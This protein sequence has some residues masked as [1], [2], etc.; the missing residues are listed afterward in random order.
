MGW[1]HVCLRCKTHPNEKD[2]KK[3]IRVD[4]MPYKVYSCRCGQDV[5]VA[6][7]EVRPRRTSDF[8]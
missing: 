2:Y 4:G 3:T 7:P 5:W 8:D 1:E 6:Q